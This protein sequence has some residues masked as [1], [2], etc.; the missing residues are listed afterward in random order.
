M[1][2]NRRRP[3]L[4]YFYFLY[5]F[6][7]VMVFVLMIYIPSR[8]PGVVIPGFRGSLISGFPGVGDFGFPG[9]TFFFSGDFFSSPL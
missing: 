2:T 8:F 6:P 7:L 9:I 5:F 1:T 3:E 4:S